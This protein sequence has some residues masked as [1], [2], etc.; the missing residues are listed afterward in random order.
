MREVTA[1]TQRYRVVV[2]S[3]ESTL[4]EEGKQTLLPCLAP[5]GAA[6]C[7]CSAQWMTA[8][9][10]SWEP[11]TFIFE[12]ISH[13]AWPANSRGL[14]VSTPYPGLGFEARADM[15]SFFSFLM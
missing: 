1:M 2:K 4:P 15:P 6:G 13:R 5:V 8:A 10:V 11:P 3:C 12:I 9:I 14:P 7:V